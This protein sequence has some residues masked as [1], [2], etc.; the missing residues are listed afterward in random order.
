MRVIQATAVNYSEPYQTSK[1]EI[2]GKIELS[3]VD[4]FLLK[5]PS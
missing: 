2:F 3:A 4:Y 5:A 1:M